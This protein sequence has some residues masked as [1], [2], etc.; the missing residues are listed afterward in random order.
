MDI[1][2]K[3][4]M[5]LWIS[6]WIYMD[7]YIYIDARTCYGFSTQGEYCTRE[8]HD[9]GFKL[10]NFHLPTKPKVILRNS[11]HCVIGPS[12]PFSERGPTFPVRPCCQRW[13]CK[14]QVLSTLCCYAKCCEDVV[15]IANTK[16]LGSRAVQFYQSTV[17]YSVRYGHFIVPRSLEQI[18]S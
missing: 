11:V 5:I 3:L 18:W 6:I 4:S 1:S 14:R 16:F 9:K 15:T 17:Q 8:N 2:L 13:A 10:A 7:F 12:K